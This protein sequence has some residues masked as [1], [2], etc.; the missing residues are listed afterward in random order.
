[1][2][3]LILPVGIPAILILAVVLIYN[4]IVSRKQ[5]VK[6][7]WADVITQERQKDKILSKLEEVVKDYISYESEAF[8]AVTALRSRL[9]KVDTNKID[10]NELKSIE[11]D[12]T[13]ALAGFNLVAEDY[14]DLKASEAFGKLMREV[15][16]QQEDVG[17][18]IRI[19]NGSVERFNEGIL[20][21]PNN[22]V[23]S[24]LNKEVEI[25]V[26]SD[27]ESENNFDYK[28]NF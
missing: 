26:F 19:F 7:T 22:L 24:V 13:K 10:V 5:N 4:S 23:N 15:T 16:N 18:A 25:E 8:K 27:S 11:N 1:M 2:E 3:S 9:A 17:A 20:V 6:R 12:S 14:P 21:F 28:P